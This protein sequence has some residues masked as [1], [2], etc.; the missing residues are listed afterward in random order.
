MSFKNFMLIT[1]IISIIWFIIDMGGNSP[2][3]QMAKCNSTEDCI[4]VACVANTP[5]LI[6]KKYEAEWESQAAMLGNSSGIGISLNATE[7]LQSYGCISGVCTA[8]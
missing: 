1:T 4:A 7:C 5:V 2:E 6:N 3:E 8:L